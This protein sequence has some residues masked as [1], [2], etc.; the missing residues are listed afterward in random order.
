MRGKRKMGTGNR[1]CHKCGRILLPESRFCRFCG[2]RIEELVQNNLQIHSSHQQIPYRADVEKKQKN[3]NVAK[4]LFWIFMIVAI[5]V[6]VVTD[7]WTP[8]TE[9]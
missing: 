9:E 1:Y 5:S 3:G 2:A 8:E 6:V 7:T 4:T